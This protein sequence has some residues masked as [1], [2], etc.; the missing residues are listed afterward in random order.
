M[1][2]YDSNDF[3]KG[4]E[5]NFRSL[6]NILQKRRRI[7]F[8]V[9]LPLLA[10]TTIYSF[11]IKPTYTAKGTLLIE[12]EP[13][14]LTFEE[15]FQ[16]ESFMDDY[17]QTQYKLLQS[18][19][20]ANNVIEKLKLHENESFAGRLLN[21]KK[22]DDSSNKK[23]RSKLINVLLKRL[24]IRPVRNTRLVE[25]NFSDKDPDFSATVVNTLIDSF[26]DLNIEARYETTEQASEFLTSQISELRA[27]VEKKE[28]ELQKYGAE[29]NI[30]P[31]SDTETTIVERLGELNRAL[32]AA[33][34]DRVRKQSYYNEIKVATPDYIPEALNNLLIQNLREEY[35]NLN[36]QYT[37][38][39]ETLRPDHPEM[40]RLQAELESAKKSLE[41]ETNNLI[42][43]AYSDYQTALSK[44]RSL[45]AVFNRQYQDAIQLNSD[46]I[47]YN[48]LKIEVENK[49][50]LLES[51]YKRQSEAGVA[52]RLRGMRTSNVRIADR[53]EIPL[54]PSS[55]KKMLNIIIALC[56]GL[57]V[58][59]CLAFLFE[60]LDVSVKDL[61][62]VEKYS[63]LP[64]L[65]IVPAFSENGYLRRYGYEGKLNKKKKMGKATA[66]S[67]LALREAYPHKKEKVK[68][69]KS[70]DLITHFSPKSLFSENYRTIQTTLLLSS[71]G[72]DLKSMVITSSLPL[73]GKTTTLSNLA[74]T[75]AQE[76]KNVVIVDSDLRKPKQHKLFKTKNLYGLANYLTSDVTF[77]DLIKVT[78]IP[79]LFLI[80]AGPVPANPSKL[81]GSD[82]MATFIENLKHSFD[83]VLFDSPPI[84]ALPDALVLG[85]KT[86]GV[87]LVVWG[88]KT[89]RVAL[90]QAKDKLD[91]LNIRTL[92]VILNNVSLED[93]DF[94]YKQYYHHYYT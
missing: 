35:V 58:G 69:I 77:K 49:K 85:P 15:I 73:E 61:Q 25:V 27:E 41:D 45:T 21:Q 75:L 81:L 65:G 40:Q 2:E 63:G 1:D 80:N 68:E 24:T 91:Q 82:K 36:R 57:F 16:I 37:K 89:S 28:K 50:N 53:A 38:E 29:K 6:W 33:Q 19:A 4:E 14:I 31:L 70:V 76:D 43:G 87:I 44:E 64:T 11:I 3:L 71:S 66:A 52:A 42:K 32:T 94:Y 79:N 78:P 62:D 84:M 30:I 47:T 20:L 83:Y 90:R 93:Q 17:Y 7:I 10:V 46:A 51:L 22:T 92:G 86:D 59:V 5:I 39:A 48:S 8:C 9:A 13:N 18:R 12:K 55:P 56:V 60:Y 54:Y 67:Q 26:I 88:G 34:I 72:A 74:V 23:F